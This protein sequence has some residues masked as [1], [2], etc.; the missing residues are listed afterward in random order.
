HTLFHF[1]SSLDNLFK[2]M[3]VGFWP[4]YCLED[5]RWYNP[6]LMN[7]AY[8]MVC[9]CDIPLT[10]IT[11]HTS[12]YGRFGIGMKREWAIAAG[13][14]PVMYLTYQSPIKEKV[15][16]LARL[17]Q[18][19]EHKFIDDAAKTV[20]ID[21]LLNLISMIKPLEGYMEIGSPPYPASKDFYLENE[22]RYI[23]RLSEG[24]ICIPSQN[25]RSNKD[26]YN[27]YT[28]ENYLLKFNLEDIEYLF[29]EDDSAIQSTLD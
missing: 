8:P 29:V 17:S 18:N 4:R 1:T 28:Y 2:I 10:R 21:S 20:H 14:N 5:F 23:P 24:R 26:E 9:F 19:N 27:A 6:Q 16:N 7:V 12:F 22:W 11:E 25:Y 3:Q 13:L 15:L